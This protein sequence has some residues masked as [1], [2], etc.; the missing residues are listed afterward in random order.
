MVP[1]IAILI[2]I[3]I[4][5]LYENLTNKLLKAL[6][7]CFISIFL[8]WNAISV[9]SKSTLIN[10]NGIEAEQILN[11]I[12]P[13][14]SCIPHKGKLILINPEISDK[15][16]YSIYKRTGFRLIED[17]EV[18]IKRRSK[19]NDI[20]I[21]I[22]KDQKILDSIDTQNSLILKYIDKQIYEIKSPNYVSFN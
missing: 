10:Q 17:G 3:G 16:E 12:Q 13:Y 18:E 7:L 15:T 11:K 14:Y 6:I 9:F 20:D 4:G 2:G 22:I 5:T 19:R 8:I 21:I 1:L